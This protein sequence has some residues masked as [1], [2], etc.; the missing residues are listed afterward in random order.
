MK[1]FARLASPLYALV[2]K[3]EWEWS[4]SCS[5]AFLELKKKLMTSPLLALPRFNL[6]FLDTDASGE[7]L[8]AMIS[9]VID[10][11]EY[12]IAYAS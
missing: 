12:V 3:R 10:G 2:N 7:G 11:R 9:Q 4:D 1:G 6:D 8:G 5:G